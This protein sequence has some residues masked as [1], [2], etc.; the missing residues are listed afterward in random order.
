MTATDTTGVETRLILAAD[1]IDGVDFLAILPE[2]CPPATIHRGRE[3]LAIAARVFKGSPAGADV[4]A[5]RR[6][7]IGVRQKLVSAIRQNGVLEQ[8]VRKAS[9]DSERLN[10]ASHLLNAS[11]QEVVEDLERQLRD[12]R[13][14]RDV[15]R[16]SERVEHRVAVE[17]QQACERLEA[18]IANQAATILEQYEELRSARLSLSACGLI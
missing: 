13:Y 16:N 17:H 12:A 11:C 9:A 10:N 2:C 1:R 8:R 18:Q 6:A 3:A 15:A 5:L 14:E 7:L 4:V